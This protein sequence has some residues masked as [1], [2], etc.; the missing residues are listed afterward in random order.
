[1]RLNVDL[2]G[3]GG[4]GRKASGGTGLE[5][6]IPRV[7]GGNGYQDIV[8]TALSTTFRADTILSHRFAIANF[9]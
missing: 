1:M 9:Q 6:E 5:K 3:V 2:D 7:A 8:R 4:S